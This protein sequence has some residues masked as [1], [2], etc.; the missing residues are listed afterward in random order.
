MD[1]RHFRYFVAVAEAGSFVAASRQL[2][3]STVDCQVL[4]N[5]F[6]GDGDLSGVPMQH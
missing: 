4:G 2:G 5:A 1:V 3:L 6:G